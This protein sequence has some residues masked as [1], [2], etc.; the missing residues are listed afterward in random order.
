MAK[1]DFDIGILGGGSG[2]LTVAA[3][4]AQLGAKLSLSIRKANWAAIVSTTD[5]FR[6]RH[7]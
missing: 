7:L 3:G 6:A 5:V 1:Y 2:G 4:A